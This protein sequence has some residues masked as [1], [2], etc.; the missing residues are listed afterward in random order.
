MQETLIDLLKRKA[1]EPSTWAGIGKAIIAAGL[2][3]EPM[4]NAVITAG[5]AIWA[6]VDVIRRESAR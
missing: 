4:T 3:S 5:L 2:A 6:A 1:R